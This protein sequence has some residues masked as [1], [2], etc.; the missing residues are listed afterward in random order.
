MLRIAFQKPL[1]ATV[2]VC[3]LV[4]VCVFMFNSPWERAEVQ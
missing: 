4:C 1:G 3:M 2:Q